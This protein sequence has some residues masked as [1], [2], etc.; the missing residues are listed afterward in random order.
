MRILITGTTGDSMPPPYA[1][2]QNV[3][4]LYA[5]TWKKMGH[6]VAVTFVYRP[7]NSD[8]LGANADYFFE[9][10]SRPNKFKKLIFLLKYFLKNPAL[11]VKL[12]RSYLR[13][14]P[15]FTIELV[16][17]SAY[18][19]FM[20][21][22]IE[23]YKPDIILAQAALIKAFMVAE[24]AQMKNIPIAYNTYAEVHDQRMGVNKHLSAE[25]QKT[26]WTYFLNQAD[27]II[28]M[29][30]C[31]VGPLMYLPPER[32]KVFWDTCDFQAYQ[33][34]LKETREQ[35]RDSFNVPH[36]QFLVGMTGAF[37]YRKGHDQLIKAVAILARQGYNVGATIVGGNVGIEKWQDLAK[38]EGVEDRIHL[39]QNFSELQK[40]RLYRCIDAYAN[41][42]N[43]Q[44]SCGLDLAL[45]E[46]MS[47]GLPIVV[48]DNGALPSAVP[49]GK[50]G[51]IVPTANVEAVAEG[52][53]KLYKATPEERRE[54][55]NESRRIASKTDINVTAE[56]KMGW[57]KE[58]IA[59]RKK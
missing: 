12:F 23:E 5:R 55:G 8:D 15:R 6:D 24:I 45:L 59:A 14:C 11:Y 1:G 25:Q 53:L 31:S 56:I 49:E 18:G 26:Y 10:S 39:L 50:N 16:L 13:V 30:N 44:R 51:Y 29:D 48:Y 41:L 36:D 57:F 17:Y 20:K 58:T 2:I 46:A 7:H 35:L 32:V 4:L 47:G 21:D 28:G 34:E 38:T 54:K 37:H 27:F 33:I 52:I 43:S 22:V 40:C 3:S 9:Y 42:S 19:V